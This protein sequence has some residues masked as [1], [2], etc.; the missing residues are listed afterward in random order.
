M[1]KEFA[2]A[3]KKKLEKS[4]AD[5]EKSLGQFAEPGEHQKDDYQSKYPDYGAADEDNA[6]EVADFNDRVSLEGNL[7][8]NLQEVNKALKR[9]EEGKYGS[10]EKCG[11]EISKKRL[12]AFPS[13]SSCMECAGNK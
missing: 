12:E 7:E 8:Q 9:I 2:K 3:M 6:T 5:L 4:K 1:D 13:A 10:C 11:K